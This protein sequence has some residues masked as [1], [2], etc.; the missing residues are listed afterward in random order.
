MVTIISHDIKEPLLGV[1]LLLQKLN[2]N[3]SYLTQASK[4]LERQVSAVNEILNNILKFQK[5]SIQK[6]TEISNQRDIINV[7]SQSEKELYTQISEKKL[8]LEIEIQENPEFQL[9]IAKEKLKIIIYNLLVNAIK[10]SFL[11]GTIK[12]NTTSNSL[13]IQDFGIGMPANYSNALL[14]EVFNSEKGTHNESGAGIGLYIVGQ[15]IKDTKLKIKFEPQ[16][17]GTMVTIHS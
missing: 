6:T 11:D 12:I 16:L 3:D 7:I 8:K 17:Q 13:I 14:H 9:P 15:L 1:Q 5:V 10:Y 4:S 2:I